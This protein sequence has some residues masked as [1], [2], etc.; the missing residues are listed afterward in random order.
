M[1]L[2]TAL[3]SSHAQDSAPVPLN[4]N[5]RKPQLADSR[6]VLVSFKEGKYGL[7]NELALLLEHECKSHMN[8]MAM[9]ALL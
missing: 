7:Q 8:D 2:A 1:S 3:Y 5:Y 4:G 9:A 6:V